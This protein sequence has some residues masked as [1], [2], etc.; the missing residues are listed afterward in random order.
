MTG[1]N[2]V[3]K[4]HA[5]RDFL[6]SMDNPEVAIAI[7]TCEGAKEAS[8]CKFCLNHETQCCPLPGQGAVRLCPDGYRFN[9]N[10]ELVEESIKEAPPAP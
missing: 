10:F 2:E 4:E 5:S 7:V 9:Q 3:K 1:K 6:V 8:L